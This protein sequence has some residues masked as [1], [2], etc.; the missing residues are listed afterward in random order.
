M[1]LLPRI[2]LKNALNFTRNYSPATPGYYSDIANW[3]P[4]VTISLPRLL[5]MGLS[6]GGGL[7]S[8]WSNTDEKE[9][10]KGQ[11]LNTYTTNATL[12]ADIAPRGALQ[13][14][15]AQNFARQLNKNKTL[16]HEGITTDS[17]AINLLSTLGPLT[18]RSS[19][20]YDMLDDSPPIKNIQ[21]RFSLLATNATMS[22]NE[23]SL[24]A[25]SGY[26]IYANMIKNTDFNFVMGDREKSLWSLNLGTT[27]VNNLINASGY[28]QL[29]VKDTFYFN[30]GLNFAFTEEFSV[31]ATRQYDMIAKRLMSHSYSAVWHL[32]CWDA[33]FSWSKRQDNVEE[34]FFS[35][36]ISALPQYKLTKPT[37]IAPAINPQLGTP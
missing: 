32:H 31:G 3:N 4:N 16:P 26:S 36:N 20:N 33:T 21:D 9:N 12:V 30:T 8:G 5:F 22:Y 6:G 23:Y 18:I 29:D 14:T 37:T 1:E 7:Q 10:I 24:Y 11:F 19:T 27:Y 25:N 15:L 2:Y 28:P 34:V 35:I 17:L 13:L